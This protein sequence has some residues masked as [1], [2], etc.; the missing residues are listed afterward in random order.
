[1]AETLSLARQKPTTGGAEPGLAAAPPPARIFS[2]CHGTQLL[3]IQHLRR[4]LPSPATRDF[5]LWHPID[6]SPRIDGF[7]Q[8][9]ISTAGFVDTLDMRDFESLKPRRQSAVTWWSESVRRLRCDAARLRR[10]MARNTIAERETELWTDEPIHFY[11]NFPRAVLRQARQVKIPHC[12]N[13]ED[14]TMPA[15]RRQL[16]R[17]WR[18]TSWAKRYLFLPWQRLASGVDMRMHNVVYDRA[19]SFDRP[20]AWTESCVGLSNLIAID[21]FEATYRTLPASLRAEVEEALRPI[22]AARRPLVLLLLFGFGSGPETRDIYQK[23]V[24]RVFAER[25]SEL[26]GC[27]LAVKVHP[28]SAGAQ[29][30]AFLDWLRTN[31]PAEVYPIMHSLN[32]EF[33]LPQLRPDYVLAGLCGALP[34]V[35]ALR[36]GRPVGLSEL[37]EAFR[38]EHPTYPTAEFFAGMEI[39]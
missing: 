36:A 38:R 26:S 19:Y 3:V 6:N 37:I 30:A 11:V 29:E 32:L 28:G 7:M 21:K 13:H 2:A 34:I 22:R 9:V 27:S 10:W 15:F 25:R 31:I 17:S 16:E 24:A 39:W 12:F 33:M 23:S 14:L 4:H 18:E 20:S 5:L 35:R 1:M 8:S